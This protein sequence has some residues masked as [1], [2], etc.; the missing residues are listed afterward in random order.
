MIVSALVLILG[1]AG[2]MWWQTKQAGQAVGD[3]VITTK[4]VPQ[5]Q[6][7]SQFPEGIPIEKGAKTLVSL[8]QTSTDG[9]FQGTRKFVSAKSIE[10]NASIYEE[11]LTTDGWKIQ[12]TTDQPTLK[13]FSARKGDLLLQIVLNE[14]KIT[15]GNTVE[16]IVQQAEPAPGE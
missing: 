5:D 8:D 6:L 3:S 7:P 13:H 10:Q 9:R 12:S 15:D 2:Y 11:F 1:Y 14:A 4:A 16:I